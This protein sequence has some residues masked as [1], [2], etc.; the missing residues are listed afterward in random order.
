MALARAIPTTRIGVA[1]LMSFPLLIAMACYAHAAAPIEYGSIGPAPPEQIAAYQPVRAVA[2]VVRKGPLATYGYGAHAAPASGPTID[3]RGA[4]ADAPAV[5]PR[6]PRFEDASAPAAV[7]P[8][9]SAGPMDIRPPTEGADII[10]A[11]PP[12][13]AKFRPL[14]TAALP[15]LPE[16]GAYLVQIGAFSQRANADRTR[17][18]AGAVGAVL[19]DT[20][21]RPAGALYRVRLG[22][23]PTRQAADA[24]RAS[25]LDLG[26]S[27]AK[28]TQAD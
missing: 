27:D 26:Y 13:Q 25:L 4:F 8:I 1:I 28:V 23:W 17:E 24:A 12:P 19:V 2:P 16:R 14:E 15:P 5:A 10:E 11:E 18:R 7:A 20:I 22:P 3:L 9:A 21:E 6:M